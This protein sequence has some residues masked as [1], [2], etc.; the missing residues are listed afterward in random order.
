MSW[1]LEFNQLCND[2][3]IE[4]VLD[5]NKFLLV[6][7]KMP[8]KEV[9]EK[10][11]AVVPDTIN[12][13]YTE[14]PKV[15][16]TAGLRSLFANAGAQEATVQIDKHSLTITIKSESPVLTEQD[17]QVWPLVRQFLLADKFVEG[18]KILVNDTV[19]SEY[20]RQLAT[21]L[22]SQT[23]PERDR[24]FTSDDLLNLRIALATSQDVN[25]F[26]NSL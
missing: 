3:A 4:P 16:T 22:A 9:Q 10:I 6:V 13:E 23:R 26:I 19:M 11:R 5:G 1:E 25:D 21:T 7:P 18:W 15:V 12:F 14:G 8:S 24:G 20:D 2:N 17:S